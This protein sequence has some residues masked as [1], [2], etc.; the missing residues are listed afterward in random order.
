VQ[1]TENAVKGAWQ[2]ATSV[3]KQEKYPR[4]PRMHEGIREKV[5]VA[6]SGMHLG[7]RNW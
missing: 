1:N 3:C 2:G 4:E 5:A 7:V 6:G